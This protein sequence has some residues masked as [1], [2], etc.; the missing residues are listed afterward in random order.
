MAGDLTSNTMKLSTTIPASETRLPTPTPPLVP[1]ISDDDFPAFELQKWR[2]L[3]KNSIECPK[4][5]QIGGIWSI[6]ASTSVFGLKRTYLT[7]TRTLHATNRRCNWTDTVLD[8]LAKQTYPLYLST[9][10]RILTVY[11]NLPSSSNLSINLHGARVATIS[12]TGL[13]LNQIVKIERRTSV[14]SF[15]FS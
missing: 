7:C 6:S 3:D 14:G 11:K 1:V 10:R 4:C 12:E 15:K 2:G 5:H 8:L 13:T 9:A